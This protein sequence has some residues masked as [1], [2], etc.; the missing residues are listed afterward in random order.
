MRQLCVSKLTL[1][2]ATPPTGRECH[3]REHDNVIF[4]GDLNYR[5]PDLTLFAVLDL[6]KEGQLE[7]L[8]AIEQLAV[9][10]LAGNVF[11][12]F[13]E[14]NITFWPTYKFEPGTNEF[15]MKKLRTPSWCD[16][17]L[18]CGTNIAPLEYTSRTGLN[19][20]DH[21]PV[22]S[23]FKVG[24]SI[25]DTEK[26]S[27]I[28]Q[29]IHRDLDT[30]ENQSMPDANVSSNHVELGALRYGQV[31]S[32]SIT[33]TNVGNVMT[34]F[35]FVS[36]PG[37]V[38]AMPPW[39]IVAPAAGIIVPGEAVEL[40]FTAKV[41]YRTAGPLN[42]GEMVVDDIAVL[43]LE[44]GKDLFISITGEWQKSF[45]GASLK[46]L[47]GVDGGPEPDHVPRQLW[48][49]V[50]HLNTFGLGDPNLFLG[51][52]SSTEEVVK[53]LDSGNQIPPGCCD[54]PL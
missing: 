44:N 48:A 28:L 3:I 40:V 20:S 7:P 46:E 9:E 36:K 17:V 41:D 52:G 53:H 16:R 45:I 30:L 34:Q 29:T 24:I 50:D 49:M 5:I 42:R 15:E 19:L 38:V 22:R 39:L 25:V 54:M 35:R 6:L 21:K 32:C 1:C 13:E 14:A 8:L 10:R 12:G 43:H 2:I 11:L 37:D 51:S 23:V 18:Y 27:E 31:K 26:Y 33:L 4:V 47:V